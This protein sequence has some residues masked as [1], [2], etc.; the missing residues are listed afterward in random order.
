MKPDMLEPL[1]ANPPAP[2]DF[3]CIMVTDRGYNILYLNRAAKLALRRSA[4][5]TTFCSLTRALRFRPPARR[6][7]AWTGFSACAAPWISLTGRRISFIF[8]SFTV[9]PPDSRLT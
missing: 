2:K 5:A 6:R 9:R 4:R 1:P 3:N 7:A 8:L